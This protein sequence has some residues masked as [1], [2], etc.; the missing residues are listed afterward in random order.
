MDGYKSSNG[1]FSEEPIGLQGNE[2]RDYDSSFDLD[3][4]NVNKC[5]QTLVLFKEIQKLTLG[6]SCEW[7]RELWRMGK[8]GSD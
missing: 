8:S 1:R 2:R 6:K 7:K 5:R 4:S 3:G